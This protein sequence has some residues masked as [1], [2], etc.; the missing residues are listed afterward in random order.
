MINSHIFLI[1]RWLSFYLIDHLLITCNNMCR[2]HFHLQKFAW[3]VTKQ[4]YH[5]FCCIRNCHNQL[6]RVDSHIFYLSFFWLI[7]SLTLSSSTCYVIIFVNLTYNCI[8]ECVFIKYD[9]FIY[10]CVILGITTSHTIT[11]IAGITNTIM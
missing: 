9:S 4:Q 1:Y 6:F 7:Q 3:M 11:F 8:S 2:L 5:N 10:M